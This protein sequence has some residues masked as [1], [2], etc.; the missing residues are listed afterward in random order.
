MPH[1]FVLSVVCQQID[2]NRAR[3]SPGSATVKKLFKED[4]EQKGEKWYSSSPSHDHRF[5]K[6]CLLYLTYT[7]SVRYCS[8]DKN[9]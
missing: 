9:E 8:P 1:T 4:D 7:I 3:S 2:C 5:D 6:H